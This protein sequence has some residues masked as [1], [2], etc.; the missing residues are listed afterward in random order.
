MFI[1]AVGFGFGI[2]LLSITILDNFAPLEYSLFLIKL[3]LKTAYWSPVSP[4]Y[5]GTILS[6]NQDMVGRVRSCSSNVLFW[7]IWRLFLSLQFWRD[8]HTLKWMCHILHI[9]VCCLTQKHLELLFTTT[10]G[11][12]IFVHKSLSHAVLKVLTTWIKSVQFEKP[13]QDWFWLS[14]FENVPRDWSWS[15]L[16]L[17]YIISSVSQWAPLCSLEATHG[18]V[19]IWMNQNESEAKM[20]VRMSTGYNNTNL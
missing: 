19:E 7:L 4:I 17:H 14:V 2:I 13:S 16:N 5:L 9:G 10:C 18:C 3:S 11:N 1:H 6:G 20:R 15:R 12:V 8:F